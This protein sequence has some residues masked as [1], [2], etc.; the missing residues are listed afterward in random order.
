MYIMNIG[1]YNPFKLVLYYTGNCDIIR[2]HDF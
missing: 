2:L 1:K